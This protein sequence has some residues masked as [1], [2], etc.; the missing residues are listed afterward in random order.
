[1]YLFISAYDLS[2]LRPGKDDK[3]VMACHEYS[4]HVNDIWLL[5]VSMSSSRRFS[6]VAYVIQIFEN[7]IFNLQ[8]V[9]LAHE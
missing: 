9:D 2:V 6:R 7:I 5:I 1:M 4:P 8:T 3:H